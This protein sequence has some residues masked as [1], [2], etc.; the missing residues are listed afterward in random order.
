MNSGICRG[1]FSAITTY[2]VLRMYEFWNALSHALRYVTANTARTLG[3]DP[4]H[5]SLWNERDTVC[6]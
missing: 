6:I 4:S 1:T 2:S 5:F 3:F